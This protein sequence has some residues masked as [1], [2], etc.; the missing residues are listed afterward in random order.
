MK[1]SSLRVRLIALPLISLAISSALYTHQCA[2]RNRL[3]HDLKEAQTEYT[4]LSKI[5]PTTASTSAMMAESYPHT[6][7][8]AEEAE[9]HHRH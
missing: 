6:H 8:D 9:E 2:H 3:A 4:R 1:S 5:K 7:S